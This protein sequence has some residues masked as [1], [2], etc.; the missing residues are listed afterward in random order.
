LKNRVLARMTERPWNLYPDFESTEL[1]TAI[2]KAYGFE[3]ESILVGNGSNELL[4]AAIGAFVGPGTP[5]VFPR[6]TFA[7]YEKL[8]V[9]AGGLSVPI[10]FDPDSGFLPLDAMLNAI[11]EY[12]G[13]IVIVCS[14]NN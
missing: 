11:R 3:P 7:L 1:R 4:A 13:A 10:E 5:V 6:P 8:V 14:P 12:P 2:A 9:I